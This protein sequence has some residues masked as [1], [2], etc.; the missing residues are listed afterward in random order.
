MF[1][2]VAVL[3]KVVPVKRFP[4][5]WFCRSNSYKKKE[6]SFQ[7]NQVV[8]NKGPLKKKRFD[9]MVSSAR[10]CFRLTDH[11]FVGFFEIVVGC[12]PA[13]GLLGCWFNS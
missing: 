8:Q 10:N 5:K 9:G 4:W 12:L 7:H 13:F 11:F 6:V 1:Q 2:G 3:V